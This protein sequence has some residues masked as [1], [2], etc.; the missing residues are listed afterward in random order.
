MGLERLIFD[1]VISGVTIECTIRIVCLLSVVAS[2]WPIP[3]AFEALL[4][5][6]LHLADLLLLLVHDLGQLKLNLVVLSSQ[7]LVNRVVTSFSV[8]GSRLLL[9]S[10]VT[11]FHIEEADPRL[12]GGVVFVLQTHGSVQAL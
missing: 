8:T 6:A 9:G 12:G 11:V 5:L 4:V 7:A 2:R 1:A 3:F 10:A